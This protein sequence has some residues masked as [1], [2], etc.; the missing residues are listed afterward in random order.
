MYSYNTPPVPLGLI[1]SLIFQESVAEG[2]RKL[3][4]D[5]NINFNAAVD[6]TDD[7][8]EDF[9]NLLLHLVWLT[10]IFMFQSFFEGTMLSLFIIQF[11]I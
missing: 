5:N 7:E 2:R 10:H 11:I 6:C 8:G 1:F 9:Q 4:R 3:F